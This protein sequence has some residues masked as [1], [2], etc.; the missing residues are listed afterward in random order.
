LIVIMD[1]AYSKNIGIFNDKKPI[2]V[3]IK[4]GYRI[5]FIG[6]DVEALM[7][8]VVNPMSKLSELVSSKLL[9]SACLKA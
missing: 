3:L 5:T 1:T 7:N 6:K 4:K 2:K 9:A 8:R